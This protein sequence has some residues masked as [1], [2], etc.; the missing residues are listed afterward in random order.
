MATEGKDYVVGKGRVF[1]DPFVVGSKTKTMERYLGNTPELSTTSDEQTLDHFD[2]DSGLNV[3][4]ESVTIE[5]TVTGQLVTD[6]ISPENIAMFFG[7]TIADSTVT[8]ATALT[9]THAAKKGSWIQ[10][11]ADATHPTGARDITLTSVK[12]AAA[13]VTPAN[14]YEVDL[15]LGRVYIEPDA[16]GIDDDDALIFTF[17]VAAGVRTQIIGA[18]T[19]V[20]GALRFISANPVGPQTDFYW[21]YVKLSAN[22]DFALKSDEWMQIPFSFE[23][24]KLDAT[25]ERVYIDRR[26]V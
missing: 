10:L 9:E 13:T 25:T 24:L 11:G 19:E 14:N 5:K 22:G 21:P 3:K 17:D 16:P 15:E 8:A 2:A 18:G 4:D 12:I 6:H 20:R 26:T 7:G 1:F 23:V